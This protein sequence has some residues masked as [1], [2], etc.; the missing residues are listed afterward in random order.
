[1][2]TVTDT[3]CVDLATDRLGVADNYNTCFTSL[4]LKQDKDI[5][6]QTSDRI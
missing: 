6:R 2:E 5:D 4:E 1:M 3:W